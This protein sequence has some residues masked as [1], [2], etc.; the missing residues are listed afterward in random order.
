MAFNLISISSVFPGKCAC[1]YADAI[2]VDMDFELKNF[3]LALA[4]MNFISDLHIAF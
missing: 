4:F 3:R 1:C 2:K